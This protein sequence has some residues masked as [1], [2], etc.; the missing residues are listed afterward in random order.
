MESRPTVTSTTRNVRAASNTVPPYNFY[1]QTDISTWT[2]YSENLPTTGPV[3][4]LAVWF[5]NGETDQ[6]FANEQ[7]FVEP[8]SGAYSVTVETGT[9]A[10]PESFEVA[11]YLLGVD[12]NTVSLTA[13]VPSGLAGFGFSTSS[14]SAP[15][16]AEVTFSIAAESV[17]ESTTFKSLRS[18]VPAATTESASTSS[19]FQ[20]L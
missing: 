14:G 15:Y 19:C 13:N 12:S 4:G 5:S 2:S 10:I 3:A 7:A 8:T 18:M 20:P 9:Q 6:V 11:V 16:T 1:L 17:P